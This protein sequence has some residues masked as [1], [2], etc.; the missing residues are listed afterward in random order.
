[1]NVLQ[2]QSCFR[3]ASREAVARCPE[4]RQFFC[5]ECVT[6]H[7]DRLLCAGCLRKLTRAERPRTLMWVG[8][9][10][11]GVWLVSLGLA[12]AAFYGLGQVLIRIP[13]EVHNATAWKTEFWQE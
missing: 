1:M 9:L 4:C 13:V 11:C 3:H 10:R 6:E 8:A 12:W 2:H 5:H 7:E